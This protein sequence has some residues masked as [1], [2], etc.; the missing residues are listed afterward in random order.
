MDWTLEYNS[1]WRMSTIQIRRRNTTQPATSPTQLVEV[2]PIWNQRHAEQKAAEYVRNH[3]EMEW[4]GHWNRTNPGVMSVIQIQRRTQ[5]TPQRTTDTLESATND[6]EVGPIRNQRHAE[7]VALQ[8]VLTH[9]GSEWTGQW[10]TTQP[11]VMSVIG[12]R[13]TRRTEPDIEVQDFVWI[14]QQEVPNHGGSSVRNRGNPISS[15]S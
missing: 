14:P 15:P 3:P 2:G 5:N 4:T 13:R 9:P 10:R 1:A 7:E 6:V 11:G 12:I 8:Y